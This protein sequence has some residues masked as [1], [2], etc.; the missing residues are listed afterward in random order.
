MLIDFLLIAFGYLLGSITTAIL[1]CRLLGLPDPR[2]HGSKNPGATN[3]LRQGGG[4]GRAAA[5]ITLAC[6]ALKGAIPVWVA[7]AVSTQP[8]VWALVGLAAFLGHLYPL[9]F[10][11]KGGKGVATALGV[12]LGL[13]PLGAALA[14]ATWGTVF[15]ISKTSSIAALSSAL[16][17]PLYLWLLGASA[18]TLLGMVVIIALLIWRHRSNI[19]RLV[20]GREHRFAGNRRDAPPT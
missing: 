9:Y 20:S 1:T 14:L 8:L 2:S 19:A 17:T 11:F 3:V 4:R 10:G 18:A 15:A 5:A 7:L 12:L 13:Q 6:D 16:L